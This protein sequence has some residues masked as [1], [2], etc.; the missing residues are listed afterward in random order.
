MS[1]ALDNFR[2]V[3]N[4]IFDC[5]PIE[6]LSRLPS[7]ESLNY[8]HFYMERISNKKHHLLYRLFDEK[9]PTETGADKW[10][11][12]RVGCSIA[13]EQFDNEFRQQ[14]EGLVAKPKNRMVY[15][16]RIARDLYNGPARYENQKVR[17]D[18]LSSD[19]FKL[20][21][22]QIGE[23]LWNELDE[24]QFA[25]RHSA[26]VGRAFD[27]G[28][29]TEFKLEGEPLTFGYLVDDQP[30]E[31][32][33]PKRFRI[34]FKQKNDVSTSQENQFNPPMSLDE[35]RK[36][37]KQLASNKSTNGEPFLTNNQIDQFIERAFAGG[38]S[39]PKL[40][41]NMAEGERTS[42]TKLFYLF[43]VHCKNDYS[44]EPTTHC[45][46]K[47]VRLLTDNFTNYNYDTV[48]KS[49]NN[50]KHAP[51]QWDITI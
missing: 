13:F 22:P 11:K 29:E 14:L 18:F 26:L 35:V 27:Y 15:L 21:K 4:I 49:F 40:T 7:P 31:Y 39:V 20:L 1:K 30:E 34:E 3:I 36:W 43:Y 17:F 24:I 50:S 32:R 42:I 8:I 5:P 2:Q 6:E 37:F 9:N 38:K 16:K 10:R 51:K 33:T 25:L 46:E 44:I 23:E 41:I 28:I 45:K 19:A 12:I 47:Y 48:F